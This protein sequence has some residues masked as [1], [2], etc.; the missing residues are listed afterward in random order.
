MQIINKSP[1]YILNTVQKMKLWKR[2][3]TSIIESV[4]V[5]IGSNVESIHF[6]K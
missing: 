1:R 6:K 3:I 4:E 5:F 2:A